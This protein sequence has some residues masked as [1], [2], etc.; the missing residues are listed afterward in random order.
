M[1]LLGKT[2]E[3]Y[4]GGGHVG[5]TVALVFAREGAR[6]FLTGRTPEPLEVIADTVRAAGGYA[7]TAHVDAADSGQVQAHFASVS[8]GPAASTCPS[9]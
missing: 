9:T 1:L 5:S 6:L 2:A 4:G 3:P 8:T 7:D